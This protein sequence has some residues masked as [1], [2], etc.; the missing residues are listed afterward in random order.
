MVADVAPAVHWCADGKM[1]FAEGGNRTMVMA[2]L[3]E[4]ITPAKKLRRRA[5]RLSNQP[6]LPEARMPVA[7]H[8][9]VVVHRD[10]ERLGH[11]HD[12]LRHLDV[13][14]RGRRVTGRMVVHQDDC[15]GG[16]L[17]RAP[18]DLA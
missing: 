6:L 4:K 8:D 17:E 2:T 18:D 10:A 1:G 3:I 15:R 13:G 7:A 14:A 9:D 16:E 11:L 5:L 12:L